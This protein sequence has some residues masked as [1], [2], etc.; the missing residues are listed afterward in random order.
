MN[1]G[2]S[3][4]IFVFLVLLCSLPNTWILI[5]AERSHERVFR[6]KTPFVMA[7]IAG[8]VAFFVFMQS[9]KFIFPHLGPLSIFAFLAL[10]VFLVC[11]LFIYF[12]NRVP[13]RP[14]KKLMYSMLLSFACLLVSTLMLVMGL[15]LTF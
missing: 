14:F 9:L 15:L 7:L 6:F 10:M 1:M 2:N 11:L 8:W 3:T 12:L 13:I 5:W 4:F